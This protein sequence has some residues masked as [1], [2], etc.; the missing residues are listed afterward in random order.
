MAQKRRGSGTAPKH[1]LSRW[2]GLGLFAL[3]L[4]LT[5]SLVTFDAAAYRTAY[6]SH[7]VDLSFLARHI[8]AFADF[9]PGAPTGL[10]SGLY[11]NAGGGLGVWCAAA[12]LK[13]L[14]WVA[15]WAVPVLLLGWGWNRLGVRP[16]RRLLLR[17]LAAV[18]LFL[19]VAAT[20][21]AARGGPAW[22]GSL[23]VGLWEG[24]HGLV[25][26]F[27]GVLVLGVAAVGF[28][29]LEAEAWDGRRGA[30]TRAFFRGVAWT[31]R[32]LVVWTAWGL[33]LAAALFW[34][35]L[36]AAARGAA[37]A[38]AALARWIKDRPWESGALETD[39]GPAS[40]PPRPARAE[41][42][43]E[44]ATGPRIVDPEREEIPPPKPSPPPAPRP[45]PVAEPVAAGVGAGE[46]AALLRARGPVDVQSKDVEDAVHEARRH[47]REGRKASKGVLASTRGRMVLPTAEILDDVPEVGPPVAEGELLENSRILTDTL[48][49]FGVA[50]RVGEVH[51]GPVITRYEYAP[52]PGVRVN[53]IV[54]RQDDLALKLRAS[55]IRLIAPIPGKAAVG[56]EV[57]NRNPAPIF[58]RRLLETHAFR[59]ASGPLPLALGRDIG[60]APLITELSRMP[61]LLIA[62]TT[63]SGKSVCMNALITS[64]LLKRTPDELRL[65]M[66]DPKML[67]LPMYNGIPHLLTDVVTDPRLAARSL[68]WLLL[69]MERRYRVLSARGCRNIGSY[70][71]K[72]DKEGPVNEGDEKLPYIVVMIDELADLMVT[73]G[74]E[75]EEPVARLAQTA[76]AVGIHLIVATQR[77]SV[78]VITGVIKANFPARIAFQVASR[79]DSRTI[80]DQNGA[81][82]L[83][84][85]GDMLFLPPG[86][87]APVRVHGAFVS[88][89]ETQR[90]A[91]TWRD[92]GQP[93]EHPELEAAMADPES[94]N[95]GLG[96]DPLFEEAA[97]LVVA[98]GQASASLLQRRLKVGYARAARIVDMLEGAGVVAPQEGSKARE[99]LV[100]EVRLEHVLAGHDD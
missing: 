7:A 41:T 42:S 17:S 23:G 39:E 55:R 12:M 5:A 62:G 35:G 59:E 72:M 78:D 30:F 51:P 32:S 71:L 15:V 79:T 54:N 75:V 89:S 27:G 93:E 21:A 95:G 81:E 50:G 65:L 3:G 94:G 87:A 60:G 69:E 29:L 48:R 20:A 83:L 97:R 76:R 24:V 86:Q 80:L 82:S 77:P 84:G 8:T 49:E 52:G 34:R 33:R 85:K 11:H 18:P 2:T 43:G 19:T 22:G 58:L 92:Q 13:V 73:S 70:N 57:P 66:V 96:D 53:Q 10:L 91:E 88:E 68:K 64:L 47:A 44:A 67:E 61:H 74:K 26:P 56:V 25:G 45:V 46:N 4:F 98:A 31:G 14:G 90:L 38:V 99:V 40:A 6:E 37:Y 9:S 28:F 100:D 1:R 36:R 16:V 63:G